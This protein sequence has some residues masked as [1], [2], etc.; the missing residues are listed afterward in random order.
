MNHLSYFRSRFWGSETRSYLFWVSTS[1]PSCGQPT[2]IERSLPGTSQGGLSLHGAGCTRASCALS[3]SF[4][5]A[6]HLDKH[7]SPFYCCLARFLVTVHGSTFV[8]LSNTLAA[9]RAGTRSKCCPRRSADISKCKPSKA[10]VMLTWQRKGRG[11]GLEC[12]FDL[13]RKSQ[14]FRF[15]R[16]CRRCQKIVAQTVIV[17]L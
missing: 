10:V 3:L 14:L 17:S 7:Q 9:A 1:V 4:E 6:H 15:L 11:A 5:G 13:Q 8:S 16:N 12:I 2:G